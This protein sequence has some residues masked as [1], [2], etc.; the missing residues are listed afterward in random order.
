MRSFAAL[1]LSL[2]L[3]CLAAPALAQTPLLLRNPAISKTQIVVNYAGDL[4][5][6]S[7]DGGEARHLTSAIGDEDNPYFSPDGTQ[8]AFTGEFDG[9]LDV[10]VIPAAGGVPRRLTYHP[11]A[12]IVTGWTPDGK[13]VVFYSGRSSYYGFADRLFTVPLTGGFP[14][15]IPL[16]IAEEASYSPDGMHVA[17]VPHPQ[18]QKAWKR[19]RGGQTTPIWIADLKDSSIQKVPRENSNDFNPMWVGNTV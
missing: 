8:I 5:I 14:T 4:W 1:A 3:L 13:N 17:Y 16:P 15:E 2:A 9:N 11:G 18:W 7:R 6:A 12:D 19:Y 10:Y